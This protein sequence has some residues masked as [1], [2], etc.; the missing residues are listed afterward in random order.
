MCW[1]ALDR[2][3]DLHQHRALDGD[4]ANW[5]AQRDAIRRQVFHRAWNPRLGAF[6]GT[7]DGD[8]LDAAALVAPLV[9]FLPADDPRCRA[10]RQAVTA[11]LD[12]GGLLR[13]YRYDDGLGRPDNPFLLCTL[14]L[15]DNHTLD[16]DPDQG[17][18]LLERVL[19][20]GN[21]LGLLGEEADPASF[22]PLGNF[23]LGLTHLGV[24]HTAHRIE[25]AR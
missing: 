17:E 6:A 24:I 14:W 12:D 21:D 10:T 9:G 15:A 7:I 2:A 16:G 8:Q 20:T 22:E 3:V 1:A 23:P 11:E 19:R 18:E 25:A 5:A 13:R 4:A